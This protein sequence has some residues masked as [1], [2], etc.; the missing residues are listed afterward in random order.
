M[1]PTLNLSIENSR[2]HRNINQT[3]HKKI[4]RDTNPHIK[5]GNST[6][7]LN[8]LGYESKVIDTIVGTPVSS[9]VQMLRVEEYKFEDSQATHRELFS[10]TK[11]KT[12]K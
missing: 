4:Q 10:K 7:P 2:L 1:P 3:W 9:A 12:K 6:S 8:V 5:A 11:T